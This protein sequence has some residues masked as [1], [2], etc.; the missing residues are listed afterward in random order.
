[1]G[2]EYKIYK[3]LNKMLKDRGYD[4]GNKYRLSEDQFKKQFKKTELYKEPD[5]GNTLQVIYILDEKFGAQ[6]L[7]NLIMDLEVEDIKHLIL[8]AKDFTSDAI[9]GIKN[10]KD[11]LQIEYFMNKNLYTPVTNS[12]FQPKTFLVLNNKEI[13]EIVQQYGPIK[14]FPRIK[15][16]DPVSKYF[17]LKIN[18]VICFD[19]GNGD[20]YY[21][22]V[23]R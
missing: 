9:K 1:M 10:I 16:S 13:A 2:K 21:R 19:R 7:K 22:R 5:T 12:R 17:N 14:N 6:S 15:E 20:Y 8:I 3:T 4:V 11:D 23:I 18:Q